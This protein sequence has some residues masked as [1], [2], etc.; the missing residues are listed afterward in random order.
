MNIKGTKH[1]NFNSIVEQLSFLKLC[2]NSNENMGFKTP[3]KLISAET[4]FQTLFVSP[5]CL[6]FFCIQDPVRT[7]VYTGYKLII[8]WN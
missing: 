8:V 6:P 1:L 5:L 2:E 3:K 4:A 7:G